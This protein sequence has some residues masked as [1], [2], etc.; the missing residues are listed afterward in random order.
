MA[1][2]ILAQV[3]GITLVVA[4]IVGVVLCVAGFVGLLRLRPRVQDLILAQVDLVDRALVAG[5]E[6]LSVAQSTLDQTGGAIESLQSTLAGMERTIGDTAAPVDAV[7]GLLG[8]QLPQMLRST[9]D[10]LSTASSSAKVV[11]DVLGGIIR[12]LP[13]EIEG[14]QPDASLHEGLEGVADSL[15]DITGSIGT[16]QE[17]LASAS[18]SLE[19]L[20]QEISAMGGQVGQIGTS[21]AGAQSVLGEYQDLVAELQARTA[22]LRKNLP[23]Y[24]WGAVVGLS[25]ILLWVAVLQ[26]AVITQGWELFARNRREAVVVKEDGSA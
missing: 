18:G 26:I 23:A 25:L 24:L 11:D 4:G 13:I 16:M 17:G 19:G 20:G 5:A 21:L 14:Y 6:G 9:Q 3:A 8:E 22:K 15:D 1:K 10:T 12:V 2:R 7:V